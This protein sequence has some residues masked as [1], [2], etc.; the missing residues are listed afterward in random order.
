MPANAAPKAFGVDDQ[1]KPSFWL[2]VCRGQITAPEDAIYRFWGMGGDVVTV[3]VKRRV[4][5]EPVGP[6]K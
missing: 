2:C 3:R 6:I 4:V 1:V 5:L